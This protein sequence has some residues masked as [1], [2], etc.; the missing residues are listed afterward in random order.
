MSIE[1]DT[2]VDHKNNEGLLKMLMLYISRKLYNEGGQKHFQENKNHA[3]NKYT[4]VPL[5]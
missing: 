4:G 5:L 3:N 2:P 1:T